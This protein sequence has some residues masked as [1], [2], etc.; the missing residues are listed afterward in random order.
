MWIKFLL[1]VFPALL[2]SGIGYLKNSKT[3]TGKEFLLSFL[4]NIG[5][6]AIFILCFWLFSLSKVTDYYVSYGEV[7]KKAQVKVDCEHDYQVCTGS[8]D[9]KICVTYYDHSY[10]YDWRVYTTL[11]T[12]N[13]ARVDSQGR[14]EPSRWSKVKIGEPA[15]MKYSYKNYLLADPASIMS[16]SGAN[17]VLPTEKEPSVYDYYRPTHKIIGWPDNKLQN[18]Y[19]KMLS[20]RHNHPTFVVTLSGEY[21]PNYLNSLVYSWKGTQ[22]NEILV[23]LHL[24]KDL[25]VEAVNATSYAN[26]YRNQVTKMKLESELLGMNVDVK[27][28]RTALSIVDSEF[29]PVPVS[30]FKDKLSVAEVSW[31]AILISIILNIIASAIIHHYMKENNVI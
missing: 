26:G 22:P 19:F 15:A 3:V 24:N 17:I 28:L 6:A 11:G 16:A 4:A 13:I 5:I 21:D 14:S 18:T 2:I 31:V 7:T 1:L 27:L 25:V 30:T 23:H 8:G 10:D 29:K 12:H 9:T 20:G